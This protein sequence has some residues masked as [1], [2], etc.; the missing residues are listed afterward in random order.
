MTW[1]CKGKLKKQKDKAEEFFK[2]RW[3]RR[4]LYRQKLEE[5]KWLKEGEQEKRS[6]FYVLD[7]LVDYCGLRN[8]IPF[9]CA[10]CLIFFFMVLITGSFFLG[11]GTNL[12]GI[13]GLFLGVALSVLAGA[14]L[15]AAANRRYDLIENDLFSFVNLISTASR[16]SDD[17]ISILDTAG[18]GTCRPLRAAIQKS[19]LEAR[20]TGKIMEALRHLE[21]SVENPEFRKI[22]RNLAM[23]YYTDAN[24]SSVIDQCRLGLKEHINAR[25]ERKALEAN[26]R[27]AVIQLAGLGG[28][29]F[30]IIGSIIG[31]RNV[32]SY[33][34]GFL[35]GRLML[36]YLIGVM[37]F[38]LA[39][40]FVSKG[41][42]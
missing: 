15:R 23:C 2:A 5:E 9:A 29:T 33:L 35:A 17:L 20:N 26:N 37:V 39:D 3:G 7:R 42:V 16:S 22:I 13:A 34:W 27:V 10:E 12:G 14:G 8:L 1:I 41:R 18:G 11:I 40:L 24:Y 19:C 28:L 36:L 6:L 25:E 4:Y 21:V 38:C 32:F 30:Y 31:E